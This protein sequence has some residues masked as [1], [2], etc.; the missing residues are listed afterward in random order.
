[1]AEPSIAMIPSGYK[2][3]KIY[4]VLPTNGNADLDFSRN[5]KATR[6]NEQGLIEE[7]AVN[8]PLLDYSDGTCPSLLLQP[9]STNLV[10]YSEDFSNGA[11]SKTG[12]TVSA[13]NEASPSGEL[14]AY[15]MTTTSTSQPRIEDGV[16]VPS[17]NT[18]FT[19]SVFVKKVNT[20]YIALSRFSGSQSAI[21]DLDTK[22][23]ISSTMENAII[24]DFGNG[25]FKISATNTVLS[26]DSFNIWK[27]NGTNGSGLATGVIGDETLIWGAQI[28]QQSYATSYIPTNGS[29]QTRL[30]ETASRG[31]LGD[32]INDSEGVLY[33][34]G[35]ALTNDG[36]RRRISL[37]D[38]TGGNKIFIG[39]FDVTKTVKVILKSSGLTS[40]NTNVVVGD[41]LSNSKFAFKYKENDFALWINGVEVFTD[42]LGSTPIGLNTLKMSEATGGN[43]FVGRLKDLRVYKIALTD[44]Q[45]TTLT[46]I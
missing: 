8:V 28:E 6:I 29:V 35:S 39:F 3:E 44:A 33:F 20:K 31:G 30:A 41:L 21:F 9:Q 11:W 7:M 25:W 17:T 26:T 40:V 22:A 37:S 38:N 36:P 34:E 10:T 27:I 32:L 12:T 1:M 13:S 24:K 5:S 15:K 16:S 4:S 23:V 43:K 14:T 19:F 18:I 2:A 42:S 45:L 46:T